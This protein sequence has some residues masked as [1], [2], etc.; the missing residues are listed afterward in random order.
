MR[1]NAAPYSKN[2]ILLSYVRGTKR[3]EF[4]RSGEIS[5]TA[6]GDEGKRYLDR[7]KDLTVKAE[8]MYASLTEDKKD[9]FYEL[10]LYPIRSFTN[11]MTDYIQT[12]RAN[13]YAEQGRGTAPYQYANEAA[14]A[15][16]QIDTDTLTFNSLRNGKWNKIMNINPSKLQSCDAHITTDLSVNTP[17]SLDYTSLEIAVDSQT[18]LMRKKL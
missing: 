3:P 18:R 16:E 17:S 13:L 15:A 6:Y 1:L 8:Q 4:I 5:V 10:V 2:N 11:M 9:S 14:K 12:D 7:C